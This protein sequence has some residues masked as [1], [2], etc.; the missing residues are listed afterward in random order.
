V[1]AHAAIS[2]V[3][4]RYID[5]PDNP[6]LNSGRPF[7]INIT[8][9]IFNHNVFVFKLMLMPFVGQFPF[10]CQARISKDKQG[11]DEQ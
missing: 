8:L 3:Q 1:T 7:P 9:G 5:L 2:L 10:N 11:R 4:A 6:G